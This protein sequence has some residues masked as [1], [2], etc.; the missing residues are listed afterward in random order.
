MAQ[1]SLQCPKA[2]PNYNLMNLLKKTNPIKERS[3]QASHV[4]HLNVPER[5][6]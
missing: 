5:C 4:T 6:Y 3:H 2:K 1:I